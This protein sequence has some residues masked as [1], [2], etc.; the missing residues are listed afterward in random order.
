[1]KYAWIKNH[2]TEFPVELMCRFMRV[3]RSAYYAWLHHTPTTGKKDDADLTGIIQTLFTKSRATSGTRRLKIELGRKGRAVS[4]RRI[5]RLMREA[6]LACKTKRKFKATTN[7]NH[8]H[9]IAPNHLD[10]QFTVERP[11]QAYVG[12][13]TYIHTQEG[14]LYLAVVIDLFSR[15]VVGWSMAEHMRAKLVNDALLMALWKRK[16]DKGL[17]W[18]TDRGSQYASESHR[19]L[20][21]QHGIR[22]SMSRKGNCWDNAVSESFFHTLKTELV[23]QESYQNRDEAKKAIFEYI[24]VFYN[25]ERLHSANGYWSPVDYELQCKAA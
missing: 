23:H 5:G 20:L 1:V 2:M 12:D 22:Q 8:D 18:H 25:R 3:S 19:T 14:W 21:T 24:E 13:I 16:P 11:N 6:G 10:R 15:Q 9:P 17:V 7:S 4:R